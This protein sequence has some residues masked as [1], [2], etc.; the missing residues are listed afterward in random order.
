MLGLFV[1]F[2]CSAKL[3]AADPNPAIS[4][5][6][7]P[8]ARAS[9]IFEESRARFLADKKN[10]TNAWQF[11]R[12]AFDLADLTTNNIAKADVADQGIA[13]CRQAVAQQSNSAPAHYYL[14]MTLGELAD[15]KRNLAALRMVKEMEREF[16]VAHDLDEHF[17]YAGPDR[18]LGMLYRDAPGWPLSIGN[19][20]KSRRHFERAVELAPEYPDN[21]LSLIEALIKWGDRDDARAE[22]KALEKTWPDAKV[23]FSGDAWAAAWPAWE[24]RFETVRQKLG[25]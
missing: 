25:E 8:V 24:K 7:N 19:R 20:V 6:T 23:K 12:A 11:G 1:V 4:P 2:S 14:G 5:K 13:A 16:H 10:S 21:R 15:T 9:R 22:L 18:N 3:A 17:D